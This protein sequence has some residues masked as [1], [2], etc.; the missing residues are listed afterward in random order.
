MAVADVLRSGL[1]PAALRSSLF[2]VLETVPGVEVTTES[3]T[4]DGVTGVGIGRLEDVNGIRQEIVI[5]PSTG[6]VVA[7][8][9]IAVRELDGIPAGTV[10]GQTTVSRAL[11]DDVPAPV[12]AAAQREHCAVG[13]DAAVT[14]QQA[15]GSA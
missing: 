4:V 13:V 12:R 1:V 10:I 9:Q 2:R 6:V 14:C 11:V 15:R 7:E 8:R 5:D 3:V